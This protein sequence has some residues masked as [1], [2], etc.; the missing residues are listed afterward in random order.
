MTVAIIGDTHLE[1]VAPARSPVRLRRPWWWCWWRFLASTSVFTTRRTRSAA[2]RSARPGPSFWPP[3][4]HWWRGGHDLDLSGEDVHC[5]PPGPK[6]LLGSC[7]ALVGLA[8][9][10]GRASAQSAA[11]HGCQYRDGSG[12]AGPGPGAATGGG[13]GQS[14]TATPPSLSSSRRDLRRQR[15]P[16][17]VLGNASSTAG[18]SPLDR[19]PGRQRTDELRQHRSAHLVGRAGGYQPADHAGRGRHPRR[20]ELDRHRAATTSS[21]SVTA[22]ASTSAAVGP[23]AA[24]PGVSAN[25]ES[26]SAPAPAS[27]RPAPPSSER[28]RSGAR[29]APSAPPRRPLRRHRSIRWVSTEIRDAPAPI[30][31]RRRPDRPPREPWRRWSTSPSPRDRGP[32]PPAGGRV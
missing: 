29:S 26:I 8:G 27:R 20:L 11:A 2:S 25:G 3:W 24:R 22:A 21:T 13:T 19:H 6:V 12:A 30:K 17:S 28:H 5:A 18:L 9:L 23:S 31:R 1:A 7:A 4:W 15:Q 10:P 14:P 16:V 32:A